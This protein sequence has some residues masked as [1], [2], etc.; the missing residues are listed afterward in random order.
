MSPE[1]KQVILQGHF[2]P[3]SHLDREWG[4]DFQQTRKLT[5]DFIDALL[6][7]FKRVPEYKFLLDSQTVP[8]EDYLEIRPEN[9]EKLVELVKQGRLTIGPWYTAPDCFCITGESIVRNLLMGHRVARQFGGKLMKVGYT[10][11]GFGQISQLPQIYSGFG[12]DT[13]FFYR[14]IG[15][16]DTAQSEFYWQAPDGTRLL[17]SR[18]GSA[19]RYNFYMYVWRPV[20]YKGR[21][22]KDRL[23]DWSEGGVPFKLADAEHRYDNYFLTDPKRFYDPS[24]VEKYFRGMLEMER[25]HFGTPVIPLMQGMDSSMPDAQEA[26]LLREIQAHLGEGEEVRFSSMPEYT[27]ALKKAVEGKDLKVIHGERRSP[28]EISAFSTL[29]GDVISN[30][31]RQK[32]LTEK[33]ERLLLRWAEPFALLAWRAGEEYPHRYLEVAWKEL[34]KCHAHDTIG[35]CGVDAVERDATSRL[36]QVANLSTALLRS[37]LGAVQLRVESSFCGDNELLLTVFNPS[38]FERSEVVQAVVDVPDS[39]GI[40]HLRLFDSEGKKVELHE[41]PRRV[42]EKVVRSNVDVA[43]ALTCHEVEIEFHAKR[44][45][46]MGYKAYVVRGG[47]HLPYRKGIAQPPAGLQNEFLKV[48]FNADG[49]LSLLHKPT[50]TQYNGLHAFEDGGEAGEP[51]TRL[52]PSEDRIITSV[53]A[54]ARIAVVD[55]SPLS[56]RIHVRYEMEVPTGLEHDTAYFR[57]RRSD[58]TAPLVIDSTFTLRKGCPYLEVETRLENRHKNHRLR[59]LFP[60][61]LKATHSYSEQPFDVVERGIERGK[62]HPYRYGKNPTYPLLRFA[63]LGDG[64]NGLALFSDGIREYEAVDD[65]SRTL[66]LTLIR[67]FEIALCTVSYRWERL[68]EMEGSQALGS[69][70]FRYAI[71]PHGGDWQ[72]GDVADQAERFSLPLLAGQSTRTERSEMPSEYSLLRVSPSDILFS[73]IKPAQRGRGIILRL[74]NPSKRKVPARIETVLN[75]ARC[76]V[77]TMEEKPAGESFGLKFS[78]NKITL[79]FPPKKVVTLKLTRKP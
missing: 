34:L 39:T 14:G 22:L 29:A 59:V 43:N 53:G 1:P 24:S 30:R 33:A 79:S 75:L 74:Y 61:G 57:T 18:F 49:T 38:P 62:D 73:G 78:R 12:I 55:S 2:I 70:V 5:V 32:Q 76:E 6:R 36:T 64:K 8:L 65:E 16:H 45:P 7:I 19:A 28:H 21:M 68:P 56:G 66:A 54:P 51:W 27:R 46:A 35:G 69:H 71:Y 15:P 60:T 41:G 52:A 9:R 11:F 31:P 23:F 17:A 47:A 25:E 10:P 4:M 20:L 40:V 58:T 13:V 26:D 44:I 37:S 50:G 77:V 42:T 63:G 67:G 3:N 72:K 48:H